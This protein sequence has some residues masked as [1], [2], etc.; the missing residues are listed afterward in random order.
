MNGKARLKFSLF[1]FGS[2]LSLVMG[3]AI[4]ALVTQ[5]AAYFQQ[6]ANPASIFRGHSL[7]IPHDSEARWQISDGD[8]K[9]PT[10]AERDEII[11]AY[12]GAWEALGRAAQTGDTSDL[13][14]GWAGAAYEH[15]LAGIDADI[16]LTQ[17]H[18]G[19]SLTLRYLSSDGSVVAFDDQNFTLTQK[20]EGAEVTLS[21]SASVVMTLDQGFWRIRQI[22]LEYR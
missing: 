6:G 13:L 7:Y 4:I 8:G 19:H 15:A 11:A 3:L 2:G 1:L 17:L 12:W 10:P 22:T 5:F 14:T 20:H 16:R 18:S 21:V 9:I